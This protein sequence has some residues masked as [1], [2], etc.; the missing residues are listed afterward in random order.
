MQ[1][2]RLTELPPYLFVEIDRKKKAFAASGGRV[3]DL[4]IGDPDLGPPD[5]LVEA[6]TGALAEPSHHRYP[7][8]AGLPVLID[9]LRRWARSRHGVSPGENEILVTIGSKE[10]I[11][12]LPLAVADP[13][14]AVLVP[15]PG[16]PVY[17]SSAV[18]AG[19]RPVPVRLREDRGW[20]PDLGGIGRDD[21]DSA[22][23]LYLNYPNNPT[24]ATAGPRQ[25]REAVEFAARTGII[26]AADSAYGDIFFGEPPAALFPIAREAGVPFIEFFSFSKTF[27]ITG[28]RIGFAIG[29]PGVVSA[30]TRLKANLD[31]GAFGAIQEAVAAG[32]GS[33]YGE[34]T[35]RIIAAYRERRDLLAGCLRRGGYSFSVPE[36]TFYFW[37]EVPGGGSSIEYCGRL[38]EETG[39]VAT[40]GVGFGSGGEGY[41]RLSI[42]APT[43]TIREAGEA[44]E[45]RGARG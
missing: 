36:T 19:A 30:L 43:A 14:D 2:R 17:H 33:P 16:Y 39:I 44:L 9:A 31:S 8:G 3:L 38:L 18:F 10:A 41:F 37:I 7:P 20:W 12:H 32:L 6:L 28:W 29:S 21:L 5:E 35:G 23:L 42:T 15:D 24:A 1:S 4:G 40:P 34:I 25:W 11:G 22:R 45:R 13:G 26:L 27:S